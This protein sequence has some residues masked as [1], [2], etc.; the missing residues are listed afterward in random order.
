[1]EIIPSLSTINRWLKSAGLLKSKTS[2][3]PESYYPSPKID[4]RFVVHSMDWVAR[5]LKGGEKLFAFHTIEFQTRALAQTL[6]SNKR[7][8]TA[9]FH[10]VH[11]CNLHRIARLFAD[12]Q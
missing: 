4:N 12:R 8:E 6:A 1:M 9:C 11:S 3:E 2:F 5:F 10:L 7:G